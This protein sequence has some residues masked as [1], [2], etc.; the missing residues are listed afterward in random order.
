[1][2]AI[3]NDY[4]LDISDEGEQSKSSILGLEL[5]NIYKT[6]SEKDKKI[7]DLLSE[8]YSQQEIGKICKVNQSN[9]SR[10]KERIKKR[11]LNA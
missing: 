8:G 5:E 3:Y 11:I 2:K 7:F 9:I 6:L 1:M 10:L 4:R